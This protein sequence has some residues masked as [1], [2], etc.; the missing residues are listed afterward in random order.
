MRLFYIPLLVVLLLIIVGVVLVLGTSIRAR[1]G[2][3]FHGVRGLTDVPL[4]SW[5]WLTEKRIFFGHRSVGQNIIAGVHD[6]MASYEFLSLRVVQTEDPAQIE[7]SVLAHSK[8]GRNTDPESKIASFTTLMENGLGEKVDIAFFKLCFVDIGQASNI[9]A[10]FNTYCEAMDSLKVRFPDVVFVHVTVP[11]AGPP[12]KV[13]GMLKETAKR[14][15]GRPPVLGE[16][17]ARARYNALLRERYSGKEPVFDLALYETVDPAN[18]RY[19][20]V[21]DGQEI[22]ILVRAYTDD[23]G[24]LN[25]LGRR[26][27]AEQMLITLSDLSGDSS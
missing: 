13:K 7:G 21:R 12:L 8:I 1:K 27:I 15:L 5:K 17:Q 6:L 24:H 23:G 18:V 20:S 11:L 22:P 3:A 9:E 25:A 16:N 2:T 19:Y 14:I 10:I 4:E 26:H